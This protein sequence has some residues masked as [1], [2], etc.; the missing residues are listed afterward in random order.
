MSTFNYDMPFEE[1]FVQDT[2]SGRTFGG[3][4]Q[5]RQGIRS[6]LSGQLYADPISMMNRE[7]GAFN[8]Q[9]GGF[10]QNIFNEAFDQRTD[11]QQDIDDM[12]GGF[13]E[14][15]QQ[16]TSTAVSG[17]QAIG[18]GE[19][20]T[21][22]DAGLEQGLGFLDEGMAAG[23]DALTTGKA[24]ATAA[25]EKGFGEAEA[26]LG[27]A[28]QQGMA[29]QAIS[30]GRQ[31]GE[32]SIQIA[33][34]MAAAGASTGQ[35]VGAQIQA[36]QNRSQAAA[37]SIAQTS[38]QY[39]TAIAGVQ[40]GK[41]TALAGTATRFAEAFANLEMTGSAQK[42]NLSQSYDNMRMSQDNLRANALTAS[43][44]AAATGSNAMMNVVST[45]PPMSIDI[46]GLTGELF[47]L[48]SIFGEG[49]ALQ[50]L[51]LPEG[52]A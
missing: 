47:S 23:R 42:A 19:G 27:E 39:D 21:D 8:R 24:E 17:L 11:F 43:A 3:P 51:Q 5:T 14:P 7:P 40:Q 29:A 52:F 13:L 44:N 33:T 45:L 9:G 46:L 31:A 37:A 41:A 1:A 4:G 18:A 25:I 26:S 30:A 20:L 22:L 15:L 34:Q 36:D 49:A 12:R 2:F 35:I 16:A 28:R 48:A 32:Q 38:A 50:G 6:N 10:Y